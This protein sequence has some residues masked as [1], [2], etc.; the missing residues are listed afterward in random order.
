MAARLLRGLASP[1]NAAA[2][3][4]PVLDC[5]ANPLWTF[6]A[7]FIGPVGVY[8]YLYPVSTNIRAVVHEKERRVKQ[9]MLIMD[10]LPMSLYIAWLI[11]CAAGA[12]VTVV[13]ITIEMKLTYTKHV[14]VTLLLVI[15]A[16][17]AGS[18]VGFAPMASAL[19]S[20]A[21]I[22]AIVG[23]LLLVACSAPAVTLPKSSPL[24]VQ[25]A[26]SL[27][28]PVAYAYAMDM[29]GAYEGIQVG[30]DWGMAGHGRGLTL[31]SC[32]VMLTVDN[33]LYLLVAW[34]LDQVLPSACGIARSPF[35]FLPRRLRRRFQCKRPAPPPPPLHVVDP[36]LLEPVCAD[37]AGREAVELRRRRKQ[38]GA[39]VAVEGLDLTMYQGHISVVLGHNGAGKTTTIDMLTGMCAPSN[40]DCTIYGQVHRPVP[41]A[42]HPLGQDWRRRAPAVLRRAQGPSGRRCC[43]RDS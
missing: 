7:G 22:A 27:L 21:R 19:F 36:T 29:V 35:F 37:A 33:V 1:A 31:W 14:N 12:L 5:D 30:A 42:E 25:L 39:T 43:R 13:F 11:T 28:S 40:G 10:L 20:K 38:F 24:L 15:N 26:L 16:L 23:P 3:P 17:F 8:S 6:I 18:T 2:V 34:Y 32:M 4:L 41:T 9:G